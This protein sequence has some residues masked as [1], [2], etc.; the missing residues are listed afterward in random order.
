MK[1]CFKLY[2]SD[3]WNSAKL[4]SRVRK[5]TGKYSKAGNRKFSHGPVRALDLERDVAEFQSI[6]EPT[7][8]IVESTNMEDQ[9]INEISSAH[10]YISE[11]ETGTF[12]AKLVELESWKNQNVYIEENNIGQSCIS[13][14]WIVSKKIL[15]GKI[16]TKARLCA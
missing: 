12:N 6:T 2:D 16:T 3:Q 14:R 5:T 4:V 8:T 10:M 11:I 7:K 1:E 9:L 15:D 13:T